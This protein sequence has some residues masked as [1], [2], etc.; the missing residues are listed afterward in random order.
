V[1]WYA[2]AVPGGGQ[3]QLLV[4]VAYGP[5]LAFESPWPITMGAGVAANSGRLH[6]DAASCTMRE[7][8]SERACSGEAPTTTSLSSVV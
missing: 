1:P 8:C 5:F 7:G 3:R 6:Y 4:W 2:W